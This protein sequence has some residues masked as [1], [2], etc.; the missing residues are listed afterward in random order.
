MGK[1]NLLNQ[2]VAKR[3]AAGEVIDRPYSVVREL[4]DN[5]I[6]AKS[7]S[8]TLTIEEGGCNLIKVV[9]DG[10][11]M[12]EEDIKKSILSHATSKINSLADFSRLDTLGF[13]GEALSSIAACSKLTLVSKSQQSRGY[14]IICED[15]KIVDEGETSANI[16]TS[17]EVKELFYNIPA[18]RK[19][20]KSA[21]AETRAINEAFLEKALPFNQIEFKLFSNSKLKF[22]LPKSSLKERMA[23]AYPSD[24]LAENIFE[25]DKNFTDYSVKI[26]GYSP[27]YYRR[28]RKMIKIFANNRFIEDFGLSQ[29]AEY[30]YRHN[31]PGGSF[32]I[33][34]IFLTV[35]PQ[36]VDFNVH[37]AK[38]EVKLMHKREI[39][40]AISSMLTDYLLRRESNTIE[41]KDYAS[42]ERNFATFLDTPQ[43]NQRQSF[44][45]SSFDDPILAK[46]IQSSREE[47][48]FIAAENIT[49]AIDIMEEGEE[50]KKESEHII[51][52]IKSPIYTQ[53][54]NNFRYYG[55]LFNLFLIVEA[56]DA[57][58]LI[59]QHAADERSLYD[60]F[61][62][63]ISEQRL[64][65]PYK[66]ELDSSS[67]DFLRKNLDLFSQLKVIIT[68]GKDGFFIESLPSGFKG[69]EKSIEDF[70][71]SERP[72]TSDLRKEFFANM[73]C[74]AAVKDGDMLSYSAAIDLINRTFDLPE[75][76]CPHGRPVWHIVT[77]QHLFKLIGRIV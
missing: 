41:K 50:D 71:V 33:C 43:N 73:A 64:L 52:Q 14:K 38:K 32:P 20:L 58:Y 49:E 57:L 31:L 30:G 3:I 29:A 8:I 2:S 25:I 42:L 56:N 22:F 67:Q 1:I 54:S 45:K 26:L 35:N 59:D 70:I 36:F 53:P 19:F 12:D 72:S 7:S 27:N 75:K 68:E 60:K 40:H 62:N 6:D 10:E 13:R 51:N 55:Q 39:H 11:G 44:K 21:G 9:D 46:Y 34:F 47:S 17:I 74:K 63:D 65:I 4:L 76:R 23:S 48:N 24:I 77:K 18:R 37:P 61:S 66:L 69:D 5:S 28:D 16:G 15:S